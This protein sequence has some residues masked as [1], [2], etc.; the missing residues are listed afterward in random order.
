MTLRT[1]FARAGAAAAIV[2]VAAA[3][4]E[5]PPDVEEAAGGTDGAT[6]VVADM[7]Y[8]PETLTVEAGTTVTWMFDDGAITHDVAGDGFKSE[9][10]ASGT[11]THR[12]DEP[13]TYDYLCTLHPTMTGAIEVVQ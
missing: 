9:T 1:S 4:A 12:F 13:G 6:V 7:V 2:L 5:N 10:V 3:C 8:T 11:F